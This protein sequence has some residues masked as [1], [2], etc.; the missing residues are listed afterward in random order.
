M[1]PVLRKTLGGLSPQ[2]YVRQLFFA[3]LIAGVYLMVF[4]Q[5]ARPL[6]AGPLV[7]L[8]ISTL[9][10]PYARFV[11]ESC[12]DFL[13]GGNLFVLPALLMLLVKLITMVMCFVMAIFI[14][15]VGLAYLY[16]HHSKNAA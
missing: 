14:A 7:F 2:Y 3:L 5:S 15:P 1:H 9:L 16:W 10:Y 8:G 6:A 12:V 13:V 11:Y 4:M